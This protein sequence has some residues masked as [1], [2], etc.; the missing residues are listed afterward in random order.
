VI[1]NIES[2]SAAEIIGSEK[3]QKM[4]RSVLDGSYKYCNHLACPFMIKDQLPSKNDALI[5]SDA[6]LGPA[7]AAANDTVAEIRDLAFGYDWSCNLSCPSCRRETIIDHHKQSSERSRHVQRHV[8]PLLTNLRSLYINNSGEFLFSRPSRDLLRS[9]DPD[10]HAN[11]RIDLISNGTLLSEREWQKF[12]NIHGLVRSIRISTDAATRETFEL[13]RRGG[14]WESFIDNL[15]FVRGMRRRGEIEV[16][17]LAF[18][19]QLRN[20]REMPAFV[21]FAERLGADMVSFERLAPSASMTYEEFVVN[22]VHLATH[23]LHAQFLDILEDP[24]LS[25]PTVVSEFEFAVVDEVI[26]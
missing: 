26:E 25:S 12:G 6:V 22:A 21:S 14:R 5:L 23:P 9:I 2:Q 11:L 18:T 7:M 8:A 20:F 1:G 13:L 15:Q 24:A 16:F 17:M 10:Q 4:R 19:Y 3:A